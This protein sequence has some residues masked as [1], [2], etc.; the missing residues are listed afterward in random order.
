MPD[1]NVKEKEEMIV[2]L[3]RN[4]QCFDLAVKIGWEKYISFV[5]CVGPFRIG[6]KCFLPKK[7]EPRNG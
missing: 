1:M 6:L 4:W 5:V 2:T 7:T 3:G